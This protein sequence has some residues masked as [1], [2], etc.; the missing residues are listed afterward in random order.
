MFAVRVGGLRETSR[1]T[2][3]V[4]VKVQR[5]FESIE[6]PCIH[7]PISLLAWGFI[8]AGTFP[9]VFIPSG[10]F[11]RSST[12]TVGVSAPDLHRIPFYRLH[13]WSVM[14]YSVWSVYY[15]IAFVRCIEAM[16]TT[17]TISVQAAL[18]TGMVEQGWDRGTVPLSQGGWDRGTVP[19]SW[20]TGTVPVSQD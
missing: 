18:Q 20:D 6:A 19:L 12:L 1:I 8:L 4:K 15:L 2:L 7:L 10:I 5:S 17:P 16:K 3:A 13:D 11:A 9:G 14:R